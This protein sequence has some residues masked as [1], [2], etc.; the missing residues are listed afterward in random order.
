MLIC[1]WKFVPVKEKMADFLADLE[2]FNEF[3]GGDWSDS[4]RKECDVR[5]LADDMAGENVAFLGGVAVEGI[6][7]CQSEGV[8]ITTAPIKEIVFSRDDDGESDSIFFMVV[9]T[10]DGKEYTLFYLD[11]VSAD[12]EFLWRHDLLLLRKIAAAMQEKIVRMLF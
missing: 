1:D 4:D 8:M 9:L 2:T 11:G 3:L 10:D 7:N 12:G 6:L 5:E